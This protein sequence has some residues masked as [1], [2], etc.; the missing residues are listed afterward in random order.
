[1]SSAEEFCT[2][3]WWALVPIRIVLFTE[4]LKCSPS[5]T[6]KLAFMVNTSPEAEPKVGVSP[7]N[8]ISRRQAREVPDVEIVVWG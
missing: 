4:V 5:S 7:V 3:T 1:M 8:A 2:K 6:Q